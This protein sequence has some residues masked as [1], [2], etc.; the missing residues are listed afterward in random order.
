MDEV[1]M[2]KCGR[3]GE[4]KSATNEYF[5][6]CKQGRYGLNSICKECIAKSDK[7]RYIKNKFNQ[8]YYTVYAHINKINKKI[9][10]GMTIMNPIRRWNNGKA[11]KHNEYF[12]NDIQKYGWNNLDH[13]IIDSGLTKE[14]AENFERL[15]IEKLDTTNRNKGY[16]IDIGGFCNPRV[17]ETRYKIS[18]KLKNIKG[19]AVVCN[20]IIFNSINQC[21]KYFNINKG[22]INRW[23]NGTCKTPQ[24]FKDMGLRY[25]IEE[26]EQNKEVA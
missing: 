8:I 7:N 26:N 23:L 11:Y 18:M 22:I 10:I 9:Y 6:K 13:E 1:K 20:N 14:E 15:L 3:C 4:E 24:E 19:K 17:E 25:Y 5:S 16:N 2:K 12:K 21:A